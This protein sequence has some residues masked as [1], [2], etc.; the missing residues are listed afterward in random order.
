MAGPTRESDGGEDQQTRLAPHHAH[1]AHHPR[2]HALHLATSLAHHLA[3]GFEHGLHIHRA[4][5]LAAP[6]QHLRHVRGW[7]WRLGKGRDNSGCQ[8]SQ[9]DPCGE[10]QAD[11]AS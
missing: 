3:A 2:H 7:R 1:A 6:L 5:H 9:G 4:H 8:C 11:L 10:A